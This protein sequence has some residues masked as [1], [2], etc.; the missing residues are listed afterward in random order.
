MPNYRRSKIYKIVNN[1][2]NHIHIGTTTNLRLSSRLAQ[3]KSAVKNKKDF[4]GITR[5]MKDFPQ[6]TFSIVLLEN[7]PCNSK[8]ELNARLRYYIN[9][10]KPY[11]NDCCKS[12]KKKL[13][14]TLEKCKIVMIKHKYKFQ[15]F[16]QLL[17]TVRKIN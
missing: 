16:P 5:Y 17:K 4:R 9:R 3:H 1:K 12:C 10:D 8:D 13:K 2:N 6:Y 14:E 15:I 11:L 7:Y